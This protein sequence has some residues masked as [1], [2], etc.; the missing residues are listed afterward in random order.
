MLEK[1]KKVDV[2]KCNKFRLPNLFYSGVGAISF[3]SVGEFMNSFTSKRCYCKID[4]A[5]HCL[6]K[7]PKEL[8]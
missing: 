3:Y 4:Q 5:K 6:T 1:S 2:K 8:F 7:N